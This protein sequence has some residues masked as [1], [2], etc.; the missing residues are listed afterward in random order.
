MSA[1]DRPQPD[2]D[3]ASS[4]TAPKSCTPEPGPGAPDA[5][6]PG[7]LQAEVQRLAEE[8]RQAQ[9]RV[10]RSQ[11]ELENFRRRVRRDSEEE[12]RFSTQPLLTDLL[13]VVDNLQR[14]VEAAER[15]E[16]SAGLL[17][18]VRIVV[19]QLDAVLEKHHCPRIH[20]VGRP[21]DPTRHE[22]ILEQPSREHPPGTVLRVA[23]AGYQL[24]DRV[25]RPSQVIVSRR[26][27]DS[28][29]ANEAP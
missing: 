25:I 4:P 21:F 19:A 3:L 18:G 16:G 10:L 24:H 27:E 17:E 28:A 1:D 23:Q 8:L 13:P 7:D 11:A 15:S 29:V 6:A 26:V 12:R 22:A 5:A 9:D 2:N 14:A 20:A